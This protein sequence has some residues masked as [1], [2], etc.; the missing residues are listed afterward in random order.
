M[1]GAVLIF[2]TIL[3][4]LNDAAMCL[5]DDVD[6]VEGGN[7]VKNGNG[8]LLQNADEPRRMVVRHMNGENTVS[9]LQELGFVIED[10]QEELSYVVRGGS[11]SAI[12]QLR[13]DGARVS[14]RPTSAAGSERLLEKKRSDARQA[15]IQ[16]HEDRRQS[17]REARI[18]SE[19]GKAKQARRKQWKTPTN[20][21]DTSRRSRAQ[22]RKRHAPIS[23]SAALRKRTNTQRP[24]RETGERAH[25][26]DR[27]RASFGAFSNK[28]PLFPLRKSNIA[29]LTA[30]RRQK[31]SMDKKIVDS[32]YSLDTLDDAQ[33]PPGD[34]AAAA[35]T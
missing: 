4:L 18:L 2:S 17:T 23:E 35:D 1:R 19:I 29:T 15:R 33:I 9:R 21:E 8:S 34:P 16:L 27:T 11:D 5:S 20:K 6:A 30:E 7:T 14:R 13:R 32:K 24:S 12:Q 28:K 31:P 10:T 22:K 25:T 3:F 26:M